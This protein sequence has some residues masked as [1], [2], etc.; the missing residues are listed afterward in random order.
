MTPKNDHIQSFLAI[1]LKDTEI[2]QKI[3]FGVI[4]T[5]PN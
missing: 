3:G 4:Y 5:H 2:G 1:M